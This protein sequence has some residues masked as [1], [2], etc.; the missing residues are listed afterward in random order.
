MKRMLRITAVILAV[1]TA[2]ASIACAA[3]TDY[4]AKLDEALEIYR[5]F[6][7]FS[8]NDTD[9]VRE[10]LI[11][12]FKEDDSLFYK[13]MEK[14]YSRND[15]YSHYLAPDAYE[16]KYEFSDSM[17]GIGVVVS[18]DDNGEIYVVS[19]SQGPAKNAGIQKGDIITSIDGKNVFGYLPAEA[20]DLIRGREGT[21]VTIGIR[22][23]GQNM[24]FDVRR[25]KV[26]VSSVSSYKVDD[27]IGY[28]KLTHFNGASDFLDFMSVY[29]DFE[30]SGINT[31]ILDLRNNPGGQL[32]CLIN[33]MDNI[34]PKKGVPYLM[35]WQTKPLKLRTYTTEG[36]GWEFNKFVILT[37]ENTASAAEI[38]AGA[39][40]DLGYAVTVGKTTHGKGMGQIHVKT[41][42][43]DEA[44]LTTME[45]KLPVSGG[46]D[47][48][49]IKPDYE[50]ALKITP[51]TLPYMKPLEKNKAISK[52]KKENIKAVEQRLK[53]LGYFHAEPDDE[54]DNHTVHAINMFCR[55]NELNTISIFCPWEL[56]EKID[57]AAHNMSYKYTVEDT[58]LERAVEVAKMY[59]QKTEKAQ[60]VD[61]SLIDFHR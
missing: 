19:V 21:N 5:G 9:Y 44:V 4:G 39:M 18:T 3:E 60:C 32:D 8:D 59:S 58:Q 41:G 31:V 38:M 37:N 2:L 55:E 42:T 16:D 28:I 26:G 20:G 61:E 15:R 11:E 52:I 27:K 51:Y 24:R 46:Y 14:I 56:I 23:N 13:L 36:Y 10:G 6:G 12:L 35:S 25:E 43:G 7:L 57:T 22:R 34:I 53:V 1:C 50:V 30:E 49:G 48:I 45:L 47:E 33:L 17:V 54:W 40:R 29:D